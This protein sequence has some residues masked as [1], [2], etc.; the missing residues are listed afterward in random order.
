MAGD[1]LQHGS[2]GSR[3]DG[4]RRPPGVVDWSPVQ[5]SDRDVAVG[6][7]SSASH[8]GNQADVETGD[9]P[10][11]AVAAEVGY[12]DT[13]F[14]G[15]LF[16]RRV[17]LT[18]APIPGAALARSAGLWR[19]HRAW[20]LWRAARSKGD[21]QLPA[22]SGQI[23]PVCSAPIKAVQT[24]GTVS[25]EQSFMAAAANGWDGWKAAAR[26]HTDTDAAHFGRPDAS[27]HAD[28]LAALD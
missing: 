20:R 15:R 14:F 24:S 1:E 22:N 2:A 11:E 23:Q 25:P 3:H 16:R 4:H 21:S 5:Q 28:A 13:S 10:V 19:S 6:I 17:G 27:Q 7:C 18:P 26:R 9:A 12:Q 8:R